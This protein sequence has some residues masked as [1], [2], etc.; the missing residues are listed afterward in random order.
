MSEIKTFNFS[1]IS[2]ERQQIHTISISERIR[3][4]KER[5]LQP[6]RTNFYILMFINHGSSQHLLD[7]QLFQIKKGDCLIIRPNQVH[8]FFAS[9]DYDGT[10]I[11]FTGDFLLDKNR[12]QFSSDNTMFLS[13]LMLN[14]PFHLADSKREKVDLLTRMI[15]DELLNSYDELQK[16]LLQ[17]QL[18]SLL[19]SLLRINRLD[20]DHSATKSKELLY[21]MQFK[22][23]IEKFCKQKFTVTQYAKEMGIS[24]RNLQ[25]ISELHFGKCPKTIIQEGILLES[26]RMLIDPTLQIKEIAYHLG[27]GEPTNF[28]KFFKKYASVSPEQFRK[29][30]F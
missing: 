5:V 30:L 29:S 6:H 23:L 18:S 20:K 22:S 21:A 25:K 2:N 8:A 26:K 28:T 24:T 9:K 10:L 14:S 7:F 1:P 12:P 17:N 19:L 3:I 4:G 11:A 16:C 15:Q 27:F 13:E